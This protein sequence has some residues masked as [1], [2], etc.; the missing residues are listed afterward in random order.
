[1]RQTRDTQGRVILVNKNP[2]LGIYDVPFLAFPN[3]G[4]N[5]DFND[6][7]IANWIIW[8]KSKHTPLILRI[9]SRRRKKANGSWLKDD[10]G[11]FCVPEKHFHQE[12]SDLET[13]TGRERAA[14]EIER[15][16]RGRQGRNAERQSSIDGLV[17]HDNYIEKFYKFDERDKTTE[18]L[19]EKFVPSDIKKDIESLP[20]P[21]LFDELLKKGKTS[22]DNILAHYLKSENGWEHNNNST[23]VARYTNWQI[24]FRK[25]NVGL[26]IETRQD[27]NVFHDLLKLELGYSGHRR[28][29]VIGCGIIICYHGES[30]D[31]LA[32]EWERLTNK[33]KKFHYNATIEHF[34]K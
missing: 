25:R 22:S 19:K 30:I 29:N 5:F 10:L 23:L 16:N 11:E 24:D 6:K 27:T 26:E 1:M 34:D 13:I 9:K 8:R 7:E 32:R 15:L 18:E 28:E 17:I 21:K 4:I 20:F 31:V 33:K 2:A 12:V 14:L 3:Q